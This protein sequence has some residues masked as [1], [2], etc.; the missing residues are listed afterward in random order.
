VKEQAQLATTLYNLEGTIGHLKTLDVSHAAGAETLAGL[1][2]DVRRRLAA[3]SQ[4]I[5]NSWDKKNQQYKG[6]FFSYEVRGKEIQALQTYTTSL[7]HTRIPRVAL[8]RLQGLGRHSALVSYQ[9][10]VPGFPYTAG[11]YPFKRHGA[12]IPRA[13]SLARVDPSAPTTASIISST[14]Y[15]RKRASARHST[16]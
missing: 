1:R 5:L 12:K 11:V 14:R 8:P 13:C 15:A 10:N 6:E 7:S 16:R 4:D 3:E 2:E 9:E